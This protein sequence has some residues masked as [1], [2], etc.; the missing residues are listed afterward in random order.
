[1]RALKLLHAADLHLDS[2]FEALTPEKAAERRAQARKLPFK[3]TRLAEELG[4]QAIL[5]SGD[6]FDSS[7]AS[8]ETQRDL[9]RALG[10]A[11]CPV[12]IVPG[13][14]DPYYPGCVW[15]TMSLPEHVH[16]FKNEKIQSLSLPNLPARFWGAAFQD[17]FSESLLASFE[18]PEK[19][20]SFDIMLLHGELCSG[21]SDYNPITVSQLESS[22]MDYVALG[23]I[24]K[25]SPLA[26]AGK[27]AYAN[28]GCT[29]GRGYDELG[30]MGAYLI[31]LDENQVKAQ[32]VPMGGVRYEIINLDVSHGEAVALAR[33]A[34]E[35]LPRDSYLRL[36]LT[37][38]CENL[39][40]AAQIR[41]ALEGQLA[42][43][44][45][46]DETTQKRELWE[47][48]HQDNLKGAFLQK[49]KAQLEQAQSPRE[50]KV[51]ELAARF[52]L[53]AM[54]NGGAVL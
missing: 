12:I 33:Q 17:S 22:A 11:S 44:Q 41:A 19:T 6:V 52:G 7:K 16:V 3:L 8:T 51:I 45:I 27:T 1:M 14:H 54:E 53:E 2:P 46:R 50:K 30:Q 20:E 5:L 47:L 13:N 32:F 31:T 42:E 29:E 21:R 49:L 39:P 37:G 38:E 24:H 40:D 48:A 28:P 9:C 35:A 10:A 18:A 34:A 4:A 25:R 43:L 15:D 26:F 36:I 23:H